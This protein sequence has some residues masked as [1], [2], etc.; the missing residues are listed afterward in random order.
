M[1]IIRKIVQYL[2]D[3]LCFSKLAFAGKYFH[4]IG[5]KTFKNTVFYSILKV[6][7]LISLG[8]N[9]STFNKLFSL[10]R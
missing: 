1:H 8:R 7:I 5:I 10:Y 9:L 3:N 4:R 6:Q 2:C